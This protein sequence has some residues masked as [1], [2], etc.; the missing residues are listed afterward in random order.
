[1][2]HKDLLSRS[3]IADLLDDGVENGSD[4][5]RRTRA[6]VLQ[7]PTEIAHSVA[8]STTDPFQI[9]FAEADAIDAVE[10]KYLSRRL[11]RKAWFW[12]ALPPIVVAVV[13]LFAFASAPPNVRGWADALI[14]AG[15]AGLLLLIVGYWPYVLLRRRKRRFWGDT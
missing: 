8:R 3:N 15:F 5:K 4:V 1:M 7:Q 10:S 2:S 12:Y 13:G 9:N 14:L 11:W 6:S